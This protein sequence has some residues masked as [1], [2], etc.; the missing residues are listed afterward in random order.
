[1]KSN[2]GMV[3]SKVLWGGGAILAA[4]AGWSLLPGSWF[5]KQGQAAVRGASVRRGPLRISVLQRGELAAKNSFSVKC[6]I[7]GQTTILKLVPEGTIVQAGDE[8]V[9]LDSADLVEREL[10]QRIATDNAE[11]SYMKAKAQYEIQE[12]QNKSDIESAQRKLRFA[13]I[14]LEKYVKADLEQLKKQAED[15]ILLAEQTKTQAENTLE[16]SKTLFEK[17]FLTK[18]DL[19][20]DD[21]EYQSR[22]VQLEQAQMALQLLKDYDDPRNREEL[23]ANRL[24]AERGLE[25]AK[26][27][28]DA[29]IADFKAA[30]LTSEARLQLEKE[31]LAKYRDQL[32]KATIV[33][34]IEG[35]VVYT[36]TEGGRMG[37]GEAVQEGTQVR[38]GQEILSIPRTGGMI[39][40][41]S[42]HESALKQVSVG[43]PC[44]ITVDAIPGQEFRGRVQFVALL[45]DK[46]NWW[47]NPNQRL[48]RTEVTIEQ[49]HAD[50]RPGMSCGI[51]ILSEEIPDALYVPL[52][53]IALSGGETVAFVTRAGGH[54]VR[55]VRVGKQSDRWVQILEG[56]VEGDEV[57]LAPPAGFVTESA[58]TAPRNGNG[59]NGGPPQQAPGAPVGA[60]SEALPGATPV[61]G[62]AR[63]EGLRAPEGQPRREGMAPGGRRKRP[64]GGGGGSPPATPQGGDGVK[65][66]SSP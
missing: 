66:P 42:I 50:M 57:L 23:Q 44:T 51:E 59:R 46:G 5:A 2:T 58:D 26:L 22:V 25:R 21:L 20:R 41:A 43:M 38:E 55:K 31:K 63:P 12:S 29:R 33:S 62:G 10:Q 49:G 54:D 28:A 3:S 65:P 64:E 8:L 34:P 4:A 15:K 11:A 48:Y 18:S 16:W 40:Q 53:S 24:E 45:P 36:R 37:G 17:G 56:L 7:Q 35:M 32:Q 9:R 47:A 52:Q 6:E 19:D 39:A 30:L 61:E 60:P 27:T 14:D 13:E 1:M